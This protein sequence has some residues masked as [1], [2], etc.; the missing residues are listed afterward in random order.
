MKKFFDWMEEHFIPVAAKIGAEKH[1]AAIRDGFVAIIPIIMAG[2]FAI[3]I[4]NFSWPWYQEFM[5]NIFGE[6]W[7]NWG[8]SIWNGSYAIMSLLVTFSIAYN[9]ARSRGKDGL[10]SGL[11]A[12][13][14]FIIFFGDLAKTTEFLGTNGLLLALAVSLV[15]GDLMSYLMGNPKLVIKMPAGVPPAVARSFAALFPSMIVL[16]IVATIQVIYTIFG[17][18]NIPA[19]IY[20][21]VQA[22][23]QGIVGSFWGVLVLILVIQIL[24]FFGLHGSNMMLPI[25]N[26][27]L[28]P[29][30]IDN[31]DMV[32]LGKA[33]TN[34][35]NDQFLNSFVFMGG[36]GATICLVA[37]IFIV[38]RT[39]KKKSEAQLTIAKLGAL[40]G[41]FNINEPVIFGLPISLDPIYFVPFL[42]VPL[43][44]AIVAYYATLLHFVP[45]V[46]LQ[47]SWTI[48]PIL[49]GAIATN[50]WQGGLLSIILLVIDTLIYIPFVGIAAHR[51]IKNQEEAIRAA[52]EAAAAKEE[53]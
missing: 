21:A 10:A 3:L 12:V 16:A 52:E 8:G 7:K 25:V 9:L 20:S 44:N 14:T 41:V 38:N 18:S 29:L 43:L 19:A 24:W 13:G 17:D 53:A 35:I 51:D 28:L 32:K 6:G 50:S 42:I 37:A 31:M 36:A 30:I 27:V 26:G 5:K 23:L 4:N 47:A 11:T 33:P 46:A 49:S 2:A 48:P 34:I 1:L 40:P 15:V 22:P 45:I 39:R